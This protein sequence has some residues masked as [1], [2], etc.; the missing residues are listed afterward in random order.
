M[1]SKYLKQDHAAVFY[2]L[3]HLFLFRKYFIFISH[4]NLSSTSLMAQE[5]ETHKFTLQE[6]HKNY[7]IAYTQRTWCKP[8]HATSVSV[9]SFI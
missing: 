5:T 9:D 1:I 3:Y 7:A 2:T 4:T 6:S 8:M